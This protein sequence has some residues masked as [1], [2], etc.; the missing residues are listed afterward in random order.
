MHKL[1]DTYP[2]FFHKTCKIGRPVWYKR[3]YN[4]DF[5]LLKE[6]DENWQETFRLH[7]IREQE[8]LL[9]YRL[10]ACSES[11]GEYVGQSILVMDLMGCRLMQLPKVYSL[12]GTISNID[13]S[14][15]PETLGKIM[16]INAPLLFSGF[17]TVIKRFLPAETVQKVSILGTNYQ[18]D[19]QELIDIEDIP[20]IFGG[21]CTCQ[22]FEGCEGVDI[23][24]WNDGT[25][26][27]YPIPQWENMD[28]EDMAAELDRL[29]GS[30]ETLAIDQ[31][32]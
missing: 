11:K 16:V 31:E 20:S 25:A 19:L 26:K 29:S 14:Y 8:K 17:W 23:G 5:D 21:N 2:R 4:L 6:M 30:V 10:P 15:Y 28:N 27:G 22:E 12:L 32:P 1:K 13:A 9:Q 18:A 3:H 7:H 24:P